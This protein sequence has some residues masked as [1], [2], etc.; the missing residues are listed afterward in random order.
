MAVRIATL[1]PVG[2]KRTTAQAMNGRRNASGTRIDPGIS[3]RWSPFGHT[4]RST[5]VPSSP[6]MRDPAS[7]RR[8]RVARAHPGWRACDEADHGRHHRQLGEHVRENARLP[9]GSSRA[10]RRTSRPRPASRKLETTGARRTT[11]TM[12]A[13]TRSSES[14][15]V[16]RSLSLPKQR[17]ADEGFAAVGDEERRTRARRPV[18]IRAA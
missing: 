9:H 5:H 7:N 11:A 10:R 12:N 17:R 1:A 14:K 4:V 2:P 13:W 16:G 6:A 15:E 8:A 3:G 18:R